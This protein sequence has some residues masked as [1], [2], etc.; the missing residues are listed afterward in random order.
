MLFAI[1]PPMVDLFSTR[2]Q[3]RSLHWKE[4]W[5]LATSLFPFSERVRL[6]IFIFLNAQWQE[7]SFIKTIMTN[8]KRFFSMVSVMQFQ[9]INAHLAQPFH[10]FCCKRNFTKA[11]ECVIC[12]LVAPLF[13]VHNYFVARLYCVKSMIKLLLK[14]PSVLDWR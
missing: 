1:H 13:S 4:S 14:L 8:R 11:G 9:Q 10:S 2:P 5:T 7:V 3:W 12:C 6:A